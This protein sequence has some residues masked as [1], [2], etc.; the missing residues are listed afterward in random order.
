MSAWKCSYGVWNCPECI[1]PRADVP[2]RAAL[3]A[4]RATA[5]NSVVP[6]DARQYLTVPFAEKNMTKRLGARW[7]NDKRQWYCDAREDNKRFASWG[8]KSKPVLVAEAVAPPT[9][10]RKSLFES[11]PVAVAP[12][13]PTME[14][15]WNAAVA[16]DADAEAAYIAA[17][18]DETPMPRKAPIVPSFD[19]IAREAE[20]A[21]L[22][23]TDD[24]FAAIAHADA[25]DGRPAARGP[26]IQLDT[27]TVAPS[28]ARRV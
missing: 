27:L 24:L 13:A 26:V 16:G 14:E 15:L 10:V 22:H 7:D 23:T 25:A 1:R 3:F 6:A 9:P 8:A 21:I 11:K 20:S 19:Q 28:A 4:D 17:L 18:A 2:R 12:P 5:Y